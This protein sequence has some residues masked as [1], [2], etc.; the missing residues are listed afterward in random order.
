MSLLQRASVRRSSQVLRELDRKRMAELNAQLFVPHCS[1][2]YH[3]IPCV[4]ITIPESDWLTIKQIVQAHQQECEHPMVADAW[5][6]YKM[7]VALTQKM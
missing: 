3:D 7:C 2:V 4:D 5:M 6:Q 1:A